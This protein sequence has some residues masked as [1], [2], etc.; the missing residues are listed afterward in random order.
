MARD[1]V[2]EMEVDKTKA[3]V[4]KEYQGKTCYFCSESCGVKF[5]ENPEKF[6]AKE[7]NK[8]GNHSLRTGW[9]LRPAP[10]PRVVIPECRTAPA[11]PK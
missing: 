8:A 5:E 1:P 6:T 4:S 3:A 2:C 10:S 9:V 7:E 11:P